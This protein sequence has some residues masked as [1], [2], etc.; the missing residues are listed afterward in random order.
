MSDGHSWN[1]DN[2]TSLTNVKLKYH[3][4]SS[5]LLYTYINSQIAVHPIHMTTQGSHK[6]E[7]PFYVGIE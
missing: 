2:F 4:S 6:Q 3:K 5:S 7:E 1:K